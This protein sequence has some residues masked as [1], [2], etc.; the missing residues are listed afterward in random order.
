MMTF[1]DYLERFAKAL[2]V[3]SSDNYETCSS[4]VVDYFTRRLH[5]SLVEFLSIAFADK[6]YPDSQIQMLSEFVSGGRNV[7]A[8]S[9]KDNQNKYRGHVCY[10]Y[11]KRAPLWIVSADRGPLRSSREFR[12]LWSN[13]PHVDL[14]GYW[15]NAQDC[16]RTSII[17]PAYGVDGVQ[18]DVVINVETTRYLEVNSRLKAEIEKIAK[19]FSIMKRHVYTH[20]RQHEGTRGCVDEMRT[21]FDRFPVR[22][23]LT[24]KPT[25]FLATSDAADQQVVGAI[26]DVLAE[27]NERFETIYW[28]E[29][30][31]SGRVN[32]QI[33][34]WIRDAEYGIA[35]FSEPSEGR[36]HNFRDNPNVLIEAGM[37][38]ANMSA[39]ITD[40]PRAW[41][42]IREKDS[43]AMPF[44]FLSERTIKVPRIS[45]GTLNEESFK[46]QLRARIEG[47]M[48]QL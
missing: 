28:K 20:K 48:G 31:E 34:N 40:E 42:P 35:Y 43:P 11:D 23:L 36:E 46:F 16:I 29:R 18:D 32:V 9:L 22:D 5:M 33:L 1:A 17:Y 21:I 15:N 14:P 47:F 2:D 41:I 45:G 19:A 3:L 10:T 12:D 26:R 25:L 13:V 44:D 37:M 39:Q 4:A 24:Q 27:F 30:T 8:F 38:H 6:P 7:G